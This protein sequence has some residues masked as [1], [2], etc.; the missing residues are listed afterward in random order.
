MK[1]EF[2]FIRHGRDNGDAL[3]GIGDKLMDAGDKRFVQEKAE[4]GDYPEVELVFSSGLTRCLETAR[5]IY[6]KLPAVV[7]KELIAP[8]MGLFEGKTVAELKGAAPFEEWAASAEAREYPGGESPYMVSAR[9]VEGFRLIS[10]EMLSK[11]L[12][13]VAVISHKHIILAILQRFHVP[14]NN[15]VDWQIPHGGG[16]LLRYDTFSSHVEVVT[17]I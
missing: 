2:A 17:K 1:L 15:Y 13:R 10:Q 11:G 8:D 12:L 9:A 7:L 14:R 3:G 4:R 16:Y 5:I 6:P